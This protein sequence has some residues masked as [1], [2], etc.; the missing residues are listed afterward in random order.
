MQSW[1]GLSDH[2]YDQYV[3]HVGLHLHA[4]DEPYHSAT[5]NSQKR[6]ICLHKRHSLIAL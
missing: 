3:D 6:M 4:P 5:L 1:D 2:S